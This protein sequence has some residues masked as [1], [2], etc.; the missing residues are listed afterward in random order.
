MKLNKQ[1]G[2]EFGELFEIEGKRTNWVAVIGLSAVHWVSSYRAGV[3]IIE[4]DHC[5]TFS[6]VPG[7][8]VLCCCLIAFSFAFTQLIALSYA[9]LSQ[10]FIYVFHIFLVFLD[11]LY[12]FLSS[13]VRTWKGQSSSLF[14]RTGLSYFSHNNTSHWLQFVEQ[15][16]L[17][18]LLALCYWKY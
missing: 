5:S 15:K 10:L 16:H 12:S 17:K 4:F 13:A 3:G 6:S 7:F 9:L 1:I 2:L 8:F 18:M 11:F 14:I